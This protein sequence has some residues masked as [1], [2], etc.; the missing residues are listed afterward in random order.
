MVEGDPTEA[1]AVA[2]A[3]LARAANLPD[4]K[5]LAAQLEA[6]RR[7]VRAIFDRRLGK[8]G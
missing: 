8:A 5:A 6:E 4:A 7:A 1:S 3:R 2:M